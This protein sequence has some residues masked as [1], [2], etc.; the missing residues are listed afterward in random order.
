MP[1][2]QRIRYPKQFIYYSG[3]PPHGK[4][5]RG[6]FHPDDR[7]YEC[8]GRGH[9][10]RD[11]TKGSKRSRSR[12]SRSRSHKLRIRSKS[13][14]RSREHDRDRRTQSNT[15]RKTTRESS[16][17]RDYIKSPRRSKTHSWSHPVRQPDQAS[18]RIAVDRL[19]RYVPCNTTFSS[20]EQITDHKLKLH[21]C[22]A[23]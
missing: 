22:K 20:Y 5:G 8:G 6:N 10:I 18:D 11:Y 1:G 9:F 12:S 2:M 15:L 17:T 7:R 13:Y 4:R 3:E 16:I 19:H 14:N 21:H 23:V